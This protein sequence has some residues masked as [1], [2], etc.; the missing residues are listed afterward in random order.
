MP[1]D[2]PR[3]LPDRVNLRK[4]TL[5]QGAAE[6][7]AQGHVSRWQAIYR[8]RDCPDGRGLT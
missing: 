7:E 2:W 6:L 8:N 1:S 4:R 5:R 3:S